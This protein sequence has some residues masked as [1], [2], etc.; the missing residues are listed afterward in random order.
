[1]CGHGCSFRVR[2]ARQAEVQSLLFIRICA[3]ATASALVFW[4]VGLLVRR[5]VKV[6]CPGRSKTLK[7]LRSAAF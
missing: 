7:M 3:P 1:M 2:T 4:I 6:C 5:D